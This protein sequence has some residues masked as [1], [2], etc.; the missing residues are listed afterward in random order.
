MSLKVDW[1]EYK[2]AKFAVQNWHYSGCMPA[3]KNVTLGV[4]ESGQ[5]IGTVVYSRSANPHVGSFVD[6]DQTECV[7]LTRVA[8]DEH[9]APVSQIV[10]YSIS[11]MEQ[12]DSGLRCLV[13]YADP[14]QDHDGTIYQAMNWYYIGQTNPQNILVDENG[15]QVHKRTVN[16]AKKKGFSTAKG[17][18]K[19]K[20]K[21]VPGKHKYVYPLDDE[22]ERKVKPMSKPYP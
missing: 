21:R 12:K 22:I 6:L 11:M 8:L 20:K 13:S 2:A 9:E 3:V 7:E 10:S 15:E 18:D 17:Y 1:C 4:W 5:F 16:R 14:N 19:L